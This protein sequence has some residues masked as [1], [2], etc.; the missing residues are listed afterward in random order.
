MLS[1]GKNRK[2]GKKNVKNVKENKKGS[3]IYLKAWK[4]KQTLV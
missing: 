3:I 2:S 1:A 4:T